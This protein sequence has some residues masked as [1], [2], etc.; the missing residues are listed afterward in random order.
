MKRLRHAADPPRFASD[1]QLRGGSEACRMGCCPNHGG[2]DGLE[3][4][5]AIQPPDESRTPGKFVAW[6]RRVITRIEMHRGR[7]YG[8]RMPPKPGGDYG[9]DDM[10]W[11]KWAGDATGA[12]LGGTLCCLVSAK[13]PRK[14][15]S[16]VNCFPPCLPAAPWPSDAAPR[17]FFGPAPPC[18]RPGVC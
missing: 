3:R 13:S 18:L 16:L 9:G 15:V 5:A 6:I 10:K 1:P 17:F 12:K 8:R 7:I 11:A 4:R 2:G 14:H